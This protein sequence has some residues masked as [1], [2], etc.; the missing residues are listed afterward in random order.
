MTELIPSQASDIK[1]DVAEPSFDI[2]ALLDKGG[3]ILSR[4]IRNLMVESAR[5]K[6]SPASAR[7]LV[8]YVKLLA[9]L[10]QVQMD[11]ASEMTDEE[12]KAKASTGS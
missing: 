5:G 7:D 3:D 4:E 1:D 6:L 8:Q 9:E 10:K 12:L 11:A 2:E